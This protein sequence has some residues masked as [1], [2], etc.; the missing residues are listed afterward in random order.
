MS[1]LKH[2]IKDDCIRDSVSDN[3]VEEERVEKKYLWGICVW[4]KVANETNE[5]VVIEKRKLGF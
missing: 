2:T 3:I 1:F 5:F 4:K